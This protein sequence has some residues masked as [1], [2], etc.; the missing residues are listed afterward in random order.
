[1]RIVLFGVLVLLGLGGCAGRNAVDN[2]GDFKGDRKAV[3]QVVD[4]L[5]KAGSKRDAKKVCTSVLSAALVK[6]LGDCQKAVKDQLSDAD[7]FGLSVQRVD[8]SGATA[9][10]TVRS[11][12]DGRQ[13]VQRLSFVREGRGWRLA[14]LAR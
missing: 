14:G 1:M 5:G 12:V 4:D 3:A 7:V 13:R 9:T 2:A 6:R 11:K 10:A 8:V